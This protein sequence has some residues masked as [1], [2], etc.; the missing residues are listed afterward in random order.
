MLDSDL[1]VYNKIPDNGIEVDC[2]GFVIDWVV[3]MDHEE[4]IKNKFCYCTRCNGYIPGT[5]IQ[6]GENSIGPLCGRC[7]TSYR[8][9]RCGKELAFNGYMS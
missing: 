3:L 8:C 5:P 6:E 1:P 9:R 7:G 4:K 2:Y